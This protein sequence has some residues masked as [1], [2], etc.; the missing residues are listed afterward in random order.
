[1][2]GKK[3]AKK[4]GRKSPHTS[5]PKAKSPPKA[6]ASTAA[7]PPRKPPAPPVTPAPPPEP[8]DDQ[9]DRVRQRQAAISREQSKQSREIGE[10]IDIADV[11]RRESCRESLR[12]FCETY[13]PEAFALGWSEDHLRVIARIEEAAT[14]GALY[15]LA[16]PRGSGKS[17]ICRMAALWIVSYSICRY[18]FL[19]G[20]NKDKAEDT[21]TTIKTL[22]RFLP[23]YVD[24]FP[25][26]AGPAIALG[27][28]ANRASG[29]ICKGRSTLI[30]WASDRIVLPTVPP[31]ANWTAGCST[32]AVREDGMAPSSG[33][34]ISTSG[35]TGD[36]IRGSLLT[37]STGELVRPDFVLIDDPQT[38]ES[39][40][41][42]TQNA[43]RKKLISADVLGMAGPGQRISAVMPCTVI[44]KG[45]CAD[46][47]LDRTKNP[48]W[49]GERM[50]LLRSL[51]TNLKA[52]EP[53][54]EVYDAGALAEP[55]DFTE[56]NAYYLAHRAE[57][58]AG[59]EASW[60]ERK[61]DEEVSAVQHAMHLYHRDRWAF[62]SE[63]QN[64][65]LT[66]DT[67]PV[68]KRLDAGVLAARRNG[69]P[70]LQVPRECTRL[71]AF[72]DCGKEV[73]WYVVVGWDER[74]SGGVVDYGWWPAQHKEYFVNADPP[75][76]MSDLYPGFSEEQLLFAGLADLTEV[77]LGRQYKRHGTAEV[78]SVDRCLID[79]GWQDKVVYQFCRESAFTAILLPSK[80]HVPKTLGATPMSRWQARP[81]ERAAKA[82]QPSWRVGP[83]GTGKG[84][85]CLF[86][87]N[88]WKTFTAERLTTPPGGGGC[89]QLFE[90]TS[91]GHRL[92]ADHCTAE[93]G[94]SAT[95]DDGRRFTRWE[96]KPNRDNHLWDCVVGCAVGA[97]TLNLEW[98]ANSARA[99]GPRPAKPREKW[100]EIQRRKMQERGQGA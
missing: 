18:L 14:L 65:P 55:P 71:T 73:L 12:L 61:L 53:Y 80:G 41:S 36:G 37:L 89:L 11:G 94:V 44:A 1:M 39:A 70:R 24:D 93:L 95:T 6:R 85:H 20:A 82:G 90:E 30:E 69:V 81:G 23:T 8:P 50:K 97:G 52:W 59:A 32:R 77:I 51:P 4:G 100:S 34:V 40:H 68:A 31:P 3:P 78:L 38:D 21:L 47:I 87:T 7:K 9:G 25:E 46:E 74:F 72:I 60:A 42:K 45:D 84:R 75:R 83:V 62:F 5:E 16:M 64:D 27:G 26:I 22:I 91:E 56:A 49:R 35:L 76:P 58:D 57:L 28:I 19:I 54:F 79:E 43:T 63:Y 29:Q 96:K 15:A 48:L 67:G 99:G 2:P 33:L 13:N 92:L 66:E 88:E 17:T 10:P 98:S 86:E